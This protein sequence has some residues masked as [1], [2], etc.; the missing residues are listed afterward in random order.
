MTPVEEQSRG[1]KCLIVSYGYPIG[2]SWSLNLLCE[3]ISKL[4]IATSFEGK[5]VQEKQRI[6]NSRTQCGVS[7]FVIRV[8]KIQVNE[9]KNMRS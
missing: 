1:Q 9:Q 7:W 8:A 3:I 5:R 2:F 6:V 4:K